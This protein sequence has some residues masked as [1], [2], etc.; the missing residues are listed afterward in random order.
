MIMMMMYYDLMSTRKLTMGSQLSLAHNAKVKTDMP[1]K[2]E[3]QL[4]SM[5]SVRWLER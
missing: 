2:N 3:K 4:E 1:E 5:E